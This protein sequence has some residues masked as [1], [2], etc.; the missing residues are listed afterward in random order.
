LRG[1]KGKPAPESLKLI[2]GLPGG[3][4]SSAQVSFSWPYAL[5][6]AQKTADIIKK[7]M[8]TENIQYNDIVIEYLG[9]NSIGGPTA[10]IPPEDMI[11]EVILRVAIEC[12]EKRDA[13]EF[14]KLFPPLYINTFPFVGGLRG[15]S[16]VG[17][18][19][20]QWSCLVPRTLLD[21]KVSAS[22]VEC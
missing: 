20:N 1:I 6:K 12:D 17:G 14:R 22:V 4:M 13:V 16:H 18:L 2:M 5:E 10:P 3:W 15:T 8:E 19:L 21:G 11:N 9:V 7:R